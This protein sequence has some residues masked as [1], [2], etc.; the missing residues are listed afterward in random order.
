LN[1]A[2]AIVA[3][4]L[5]VT[6][7]C[8]SVPG[9]SKR[10]VT[11]GVE[12]IRVRYGPRRLETLAATGAMYKEARGRKAVLVV[13]M[14]FCM[15]VKTARELRRGPSVAYG[16]WWV[17]GGVVA[18]IAARLSGK[19]SIVHLHGSDVEIAKTNPMRFLARAVLR[20]ANQRLAA[21]DDL[22]R[23][24]TQLCERDVHTLSM[25]LEFDRLPTPSPVP[26]D[27]YVLGVGRLVPEKGFDVL[28]NAVGS[29]EESSRPQV[30]I[31]GNGPEREALAKKA[32]QA[33]VD[34]HLPGAVSP[35]E[36]GQWYQRARIVAVPSLREGFG[37]V[38]A[39]ASAAGRAVVASAVGGI[40]E[41][42]VDGVS[43]LLVK[44]GSVEDFASALRSVDPRW[45]ENGPP[46]VSQLG[47]GAHGKIVSEM[48][49][50]HIR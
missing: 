28:I 25:P 29:L 2:R 21:S 24:S 10:Q 41:I 8:P 17:P 31:V 14:I 16:H 50:Q 27:G 46:R 37:L 30:V 32:A 15:I 6:V 34:L 11:D 33:R 23:W 22:A 5:K 47:M 13:P 4:G 42:I 1:Q 40:P 43:G 9:L 26:N 45:G 12:I 35:T 19:R 20:F 49:D 18:V 44:P 39:E 7:V 36:L 38:A 3:T 48:L